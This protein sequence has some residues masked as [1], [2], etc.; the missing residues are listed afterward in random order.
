MPGPARIRCGLLGG[1]GASPPSSATYMNHEQLE[2]QR[3]EEQVQA[4]CVEAGKGSKEEGRRYWVDDQGRLHVSVTIGLPLI[5]WLFRLLRR[6]GVT[7]STG[8]S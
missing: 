8:S 4:A 7:D 3:I 2:A 1:W 6:R 5:P